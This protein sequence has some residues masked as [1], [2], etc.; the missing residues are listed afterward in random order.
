MEICSALD[1]HDADICGQ[2]VL[3]TETGRVF[4]IAPE[5]TAAQNWEGRYNDLNKLT[6]KQL[7]QLQTSKSDWHAR[8]ARVILQSRA[9]KGKTG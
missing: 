4:R 6:D 9:A 3:N 2:K 8:R 5:K 1:W 7:V